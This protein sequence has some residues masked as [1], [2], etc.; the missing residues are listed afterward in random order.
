MTT[1]GELMAEL[2]ARDVTLRLDGE[3][4]AYDAPAGTLTEADL[5]RIGAHKTRIIQLLCSVP[6]SPTLICFPGTVRVITA[7]HMSSCTNST[8]A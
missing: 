8:R 1:I 2:Q 4:L 3:Q 7:E 5:A 6:P